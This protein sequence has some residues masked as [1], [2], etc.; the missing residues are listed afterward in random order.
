MHKANMTSED[1]EEADFCNPSQIMK[2]G[3]LR[4]LSDQQSTR[5]YKIH[6]NRGN[7]TY[8][9]ISYFCKILLSFMIF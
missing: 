8:A 9:L 7:H 5:R 6:Q 2:F 1:Q 4:F 3:I